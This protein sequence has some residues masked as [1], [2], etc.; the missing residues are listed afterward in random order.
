MSKVAALITISALTPTFSLISTFAL[1][2]RNMRYYLLSLK[3]T[4]F[5]L[6]WQNTSAFYGNLS[7]ESVLESEWKKLQTVVIDLIIIPPL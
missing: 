5:F 4:N 1:K 3:I 6:Y 7:V 2:Y